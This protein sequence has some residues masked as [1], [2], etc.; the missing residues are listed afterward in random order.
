[1]IG[2]DLAVAIGSSEPKPA[3]LDLLQEHLAD[4]SHRRQ[5]AIVVPQAIVGMGIGGDD[6]P[7]TA[8]LD[9]LRILLAQI[10]KEHLLA[11]AADFMTAVLFG[12][13]QNPEIDPGRV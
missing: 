11:E 13:A 12:L 5:V 8:F 10:L 4:V 3:L 1:M 9:R 2:V 7:R 6:P